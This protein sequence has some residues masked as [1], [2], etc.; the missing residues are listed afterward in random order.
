M[1]QFL[2][3][4]LFINQLN[5]IHSLDNGVFQDN[6]HQSIQLRQ[7]YFPYY[8]QT[9]DLI[10]TILN[11]QQRLTTLNCDQSLIKFRNG[12][13]NFEEWALKCM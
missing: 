6:V 11:D 10:D 12:L 9:L 1:H 3:L 13:V 7:F 8:N 4:F 5:S 2:I